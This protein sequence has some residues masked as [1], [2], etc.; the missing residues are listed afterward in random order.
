MGPSAD[1]HG[2]ASSE[3]KSDPPNKQMK[4]RAYMA[5]TITK[6]TRSTKTKGAREGT[7]GEPRQ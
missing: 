3:I 2:E 4:Q 1:R 6:N 5:A 7:Q